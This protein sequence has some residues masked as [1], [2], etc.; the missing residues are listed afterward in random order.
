MVNDQISDTL[1]RIRNASKAKHHIVTVSCTKITEAIVIILKREGFIENYEIVASQEDS[2]VLVSMIIIS[3]KY[4]GKKQK[5][6]ITKLERISKPGARV[7]SRA[8]KLPV[9]LGKMGIAIVSTSVG[10]MTDDEARKLKIGGELL[11]YIW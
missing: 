7:Y 8:K 3:L 2:S 5:P 4:F 1:T 10:V 11:C 6:A 9:I